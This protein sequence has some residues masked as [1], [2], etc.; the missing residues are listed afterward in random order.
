LWRQKQIDADLPAG[1]KEFRISQEDFAVAGGKIRRERIEIHPAERELSDLHGTGDIVLHGRGLSEP[2]C[3]LKS[4]CGGKLEV[5]ER[6]VLWQ[7]PPKG[8]RHQIAGKLKIQRAILPSRGKI[9][10][11]LRSAHL[12]AFDGQNLLLVIR[13][14]FNALDTPVGSDDWPA[15]Q[16]NW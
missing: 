5:L 6:R 1:G 4:R 7:Q 3:G 8:F 15:A 9:Q 12:Q 16:R 11:P 14:G 2:P 13:F 10:G